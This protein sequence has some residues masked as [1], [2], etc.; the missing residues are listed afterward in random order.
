MRI[1]E[2]EDA[3]F[4]RWGQEQGYGDAFVK[5]G[6]PNPAQ[7]EKE[8]TKITFVLKEAN[9]M[10]KESFGS[11]KPDRD[12]RIW[13]DYCG[14]IPATW[15]NITRWSKA[16]LE[17]GEYLENV[18][19][20]DRFHWLKRISFL[21]LKKVSGGSSSNRKEIKHYARKDAKY[22][23][24]QLAIY[25]PDIAVCCGID[26][27]ADCLG[28]CLFSV[29]REWDYH[30]DYYRSCC[31][32]YAQ[33]YGKESRTAILNCYHPQA[34]NYKSEYMFEALSK[35]APELLSGR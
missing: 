16:I 26:L 14:G 19:E 5:D 2:Q 24:E 17:G 9:D 29:E 13:I 27:V 25:Q 12:M 23:L 34:T 3:L 28:K 32:F 21:N 33:V 10:Q 11:E 7:F 4:E 20:D 15:N 35:I 8:K 30:A 1:R 18:I 6:A 22:I 31:A